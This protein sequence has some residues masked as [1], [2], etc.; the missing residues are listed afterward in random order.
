MTIRNNPEYGT[1]SNKK[2]WV[3][4]EFKNSKENGLGIALPAGRVRFY[5]RDDTDGS[6][7][8]TGE[9]NLDHT[10]EGETV[11]LYTGDSV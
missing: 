9:N 2:V 4:R 5:R 3:M 8:F 11:R 7:Q 10:P 6:V 1:Q